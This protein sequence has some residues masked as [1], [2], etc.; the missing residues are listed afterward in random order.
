[1]RRVES[2]RRSVLLLSDAHLGSGADTDLRSRLLIELLEGFRSSAREIFLLGDLFD[3][4][5]EYRHA[6]PK[7]HFRILRTLADFVDAGVPVHYIGG[8]H[9]FWCGSHLSREIGAQ[10]HTKPVAL[11]RQD[12]HLFLAHGDALGPG[13]HGYRLLKA[14]LRHPLAIGLYRMVHPDL[15]IPLAHRLS[16]T[17]RRHTRDRAAYLRDM[18]RHVAQ[19]RFAEGHDAIVVGHVHDPLHLRD[20]RDRDFLVVGDWLDHFTYARLE[21]GKLSLERFRP[22]KPPEI[23]PSQ[24]WPEGFDP[25]G[26]N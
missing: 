10:V 24:P 5:F 8:N 25:A 11:R 13:D 23:V 7:G 15:G 18:S 6:I 4:W 19:P 21:D 16:T 2:T 9:D 1:M 20:R 3:F 12:R 22:G 26:S 14:V 17:S